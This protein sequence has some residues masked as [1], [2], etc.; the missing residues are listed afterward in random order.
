MRIVLA[1]EISPDNCRLWDLK[2]NEKLDKDRFRRD[3]GR[4]EEAYQEVARRLGILHR[5][6]ARRSRA[7]RYQR[8]AD[9]PIMKARVFVMPK[10][11][12]LDP[13]GKAIGHALGTLGFNGVGEV[14]QGK[15]IELELRAAERKRGPRRAR[16]DVQEAPRQHRDRELPRRDRR[17]MVGPLDLRHDFS[18]PSLRGAQRRSNPVWGQTGLLRFARNDGA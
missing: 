5:G 13:Q 2:T 7:R 18:T 10:D 9:G 6:R 8:P 17:V 1:D 3:L 14:R 16:A 12:V 4:V 15:V 11:G